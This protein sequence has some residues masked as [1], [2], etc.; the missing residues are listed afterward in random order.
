MKR[1]ICAMLCAATMTSGLSALAATGDDA[2]IRQV[3]N[4][5]GIV[6]SDRLGDAATRAEFAKMLVSASKSRDTVPA[7][8]SASPF[9][10]VPYTHWSASYIKAAATENWMSGYLDGS[11]RPGNR[12]TTAEAVTAVLRLLGY[13]GEDFAGGYPSGQLALGR[14][15]GLLDGIPASA[16]HSMTRADSMRLFY[17]LLSVKPKGGDQ[18]YFTTLG[19]KLT[20][21]GTPDYN[22]LLQKKLRGPVIVPVSGWRTVL[23]ITP[24]TVYRNGSLSTAAALQPY[25]VLYFTPDQK[26]VWAYARRVTGV[27]EKASP[28]KQLPTSVTVSGAE[29][30]VTGAG[31]NALG[32]QGTLPLGSNVMLVL[33]RDGEVV[34]AYPAAAAQNDLVGLVVAK[35]TQ[36]YPVANGANYTAQ[37]L[38]LFATDGERHIV[39]SGKLSASVGDLV[40]VSYGSDG[41]QLTRITRTGS[42]TGRVNAAANRVGSETIAPD[43]QIIDITETGGTRVFLPR[44]D[45]LSLR[46]TQA[47]YAEKNTRGEITRLIL[48]DVTGDA[49]T[50]GLV[51]SVTEQRE[52]NPNGNYAFL[53]GSERKEVNTPGRI[54]SA[55]TGPSRFLFAENGDTT[56]VR[57]LTE[58]KNVSAINGLTIQGADGTHTLWDRALTYR[59]VNGAYTLMDRNEVNTASYRVQAFYDREDAQGGRVRI[60]IATPNA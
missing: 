42:L 58:L 47:I 27:Y 12:V 1:L 14:T 6:S 21:D 51:L 38:T 19:G 10:D 40:R 52:E 43:A 26:S 4:T 29:Y 54:L 41:A 9:R 13:G 34:D 16:G 23:P 28:N 60:L 8:G 33:G 17:N 31:V 32:A 5:L 55:R 49:N 53:L 22:A 24:Q 46:D 3:T 2:T 48:N 50:Y 30:R 25:D 37:T 18:V 56:A 59:Y 11:F 20:T 44:L 45:G 39:Q 15:L 35:G 7:A 36:E 57:P